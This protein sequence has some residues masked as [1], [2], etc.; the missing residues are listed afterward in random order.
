MSLGEVNMSGMNN[1]SVPMISPEGHII[2]GG[3]DVQRIQKQYGKNN[4]NDVEKGRSKTNN[5]ISTTMMKER[6][7]AMVVSP[8]NN[9]NFN[10]TTVGD[11]RGVETQS[12]MITTLNLPPAM[13]S[14]PLATTTTTK[15]Q[16][17]ALIS[18]ESSTTSIKQHNIYQT[19]RKI[20]SPPTGV[21]PF[22]L[23]STS[24]K[25]NNN[26]IQKTISSKNYSPL[27][28]NTKQYI[29][30]NSPFRTSSQIL[31]DK[32][33][34]IMK[35][36]NSLEDKINNYNNYEDEEEEEDD[37]DGEGQC[38]V[39]YSEEGGMILYTSS[40][41]NVAIAVNNGECINNNTSPEENNTN[42]S[43]EITNNAEVQLTFHTPNEEEDSQAIGQ[44]TTAG[45]MYHTAKD[46]LAPSSVMNE[47][48]GFSSSSGSAENRYTNLHH[49]RGNSKEGMMPGAVVAQSTMDDT[50]FDSTTTASSS[51]NIKLRRVLW[52]ADTVGGGEEDHIANGDD[53]DQSEK[54]NSHT[55]FN[56]TFKRIEGSKLKDKQQPPS[57]TIINSTTN[58]NRSANEGND[59][60][61]QST[62]VQDSSPPLQDHQLDTSLERSQLL[63][64]V[65]EMNNQLNELLHDR[66]SLIAHRD[67]SAK[68]SKRYKSE[69]KTLV[70]EV[71]TLESGMQDALQLVQDVQKVAVTK[72]EEV[73]EL[74]KLLLNR[75]AKVE[76][77]QSMLTLKEEEVK[78]LSSTAKMKEEEWN[79]KLD[80]T[81]QQHKEDLERLTIQLTKTHSEEMERVRS[82]SQ[83]DHMSTLQHTEIEAHSAPVSQRVTKA[84]SSYSINSVQHQEEKHSK[85]YCTV[86]YVEGSGDKNDNVDISSDFESLSFYIGHEEGFRFFS[87]ID[88]SDISETSSERDS[89]VENESAEILPTSASLEGSATQKSPCENV[90]ANVSMI[91]SK[92]PSFSLSVIE[93]VRNNTDKQPE[94]EIDRVTFE[95]SD[96]IERLKSELATAKSTTGKLMSEHKKLQSDYVSALNENTD[97]VNALQ[98]KIE[99]MNAAFENERSALILEKEQQ[100]KEELTLVSAELR[101]L[102]SQ[103][104]KSMFMKEQEHSLVV[105]EL[106]ELEA[107]NSRLV[108]DYEERIRQLEANLESSTLELGTTSKQ[109]DVLLSSQQDLECK[110]SDMES[111]HN[112]L[113]DQFST[114]QVEYQDLAKTIVDKDQVLVSK[115]DEIVSLT[116]KL[117]LSETELSNLRQELANITKEKSE[118]NEQ[119]SQAYHRE[120]ELNTLTKKL[121]SD[122]KSFEESVESTR[123]K[124]E[125]SISEL[126][127]N[128]EHIKS[129]S[130]LQ[131]DEKLS[132]ENQLVSV[133]KER[134]RLSSEVERLEDQLRASTAE[135][136]SRILSLDEARLQIEFS[137][138]RIQELEKELA[139][140]ERDSLDASELASTRDH[141]QALSAKLAVNALK[142]KMKSN[143]LE[144]EKGEHLKKISMLE[145]CL[146]EVKS[147]RKSLALK[148]VQQ[149]EKLSAFASDNKMLFETIMLY[150]KDFVKASDMELKNI[151]H[152]IHQV[153]SISIQ[154]MKQMVAK[155][156]LSL[157]TLKARE[158][159]LSKSNIKKQ[160]MEQQRIAENAQIELSEALKDNA[161]F[162]AQKEALGETA[163]ELVRSAS[164]KDDEIKQLQS[165]I[166]ISTE[167]VADLRQQNEHLLK[168]NE[169]I[170]SD[171]KS[172]ETLIER[173][174]LDNEALKEIEASLQAEKEA[175]S[176]LLLNLQAS[177]LFVETRLEE[178]LKDKSHLSTEVESMHNTIVTLEASK[179]SLTAS[180]QD[181]Q[182]KAD[183]L[184]TQV[185]VLENQTKSNDALI[186]NLEGQ[187]SFKVNEVFSLHK[188]VNSH[189]ETLVELRDQLR[190]LGM[191]KAQVEEMLS[192][193]HSKMDH[194]MSERDDLA[195]KLDKAVKELESVSEERKRLAAK[196]TDN[197][198]IHHHHDEV[199]CHIFETAAATMDLSIVDSE[200]EIKSNEQSYFDVLP[201]QGIREILNSS[202]ISEREVDLVCE[203][204][205]NV[206]T[207]MTQIDQE[208]KQLKKEV[209]HLRADLELAQGE[210]TTANEEHKKV[211][212]QTLALRGVVS[213]AR[214]LL[215]KAEEE[216]KQL[217]LDLENAQKAINHL[218][219]QNSSQS[220][221][222]VVAQS[223]D[224]INKLKQELQNEK[225]ESMRLLVATRKK[226]IAA[227]IDDADYHH[228]PNKK[229]SQ[230]DVSYEAS[231]NLN[232][233]SPPKVTSK[234]R[235]K[236]EKGHSMFD[237]LKDIKKS[238]RRGVKYRKAGE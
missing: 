2:G 110:I 3:N 128:I 32:L 24:Q 186:I 125:S 184:S 206:R 171:L 5:N 69:S 238:G 14:P 209:K 10:T 220:Y 13:I 162:H 29:S 160:M 118:A 235:F 172:K 229:I 212:R 163:A 167:M 176:K 214:T 127:S 202:R 175:A 234:E 6:Q 144:K 49:L 44:Q 100:Q 173:V 121:M 224:E 138:N 210:L 35:M 166:K 123:S 170:L 193:L 134:D 65:S 47:E 45:T 168:E 201:G 7:L 225:N 149:D 122:K 117:V 58:E 179:E 50:S 135:S 22:L 215:E 68:Q 143:T 158:M 223:E 95:H 136:E 16:Q 63:D 4:M 53:D 207:I 85:E 74:R 109:R 62:N 59:Q 161:E 56:E 112:S 48:D 99:E 102:E 233:S 77:L 39:N 60:V 34:S 113:T 164:A 81:E 218:T 191:Q 139:T 131:S 82:K 67:S 228:K 57:P 42:D 106:R 151:P 87:S 177:K 83:G 98:L 90:Q 27:T 94:E 194:V 61:V 231:H 137:S 222:S 174:Q 187:L 140:N 219:Q 119:L 129:Q 64:M 200:L 25:H 21:T 181:Y 75:D 178:V 130:V 142:M 31:D 55:M 116:E 54:E 195:H 17:A 46:G 88:K 232:A 211:H 150:E 1:M 221:N 104:T 76:E 196:V 84:P 103:V 132:I 107:K 33:Y 157:V 114:L 70:K 89:D 198:R 189:E 36:E 153:D 43:V 190:S 169:C 18:G 145:E 37:G 115:E 40:T 182:E 156:A 141:F 124:Y 133:T 236:V 11:V 180:L 28:P 154:S 165:K 38:C 146:N 108:K 78:E 30:N 126:S 192:S 152:S 15:Q 111:G 8:E 227:T 203:K 204:M 147:D 9:S 41:N 19:P 51:S 120:E 72:E 155:L 86:P 20:K 185:T 199:H 96:E 101:E 71:K 148:L 80:A 93:S 73:N 105:T 23:T 217:A 91:S 188:T 213:Q 216:K 97:K 52:R 26:N 79:K 230:Y 12:D 66:E 92:L 208:R 159:N 237:M 197:P 183:Q 226:A 205:S